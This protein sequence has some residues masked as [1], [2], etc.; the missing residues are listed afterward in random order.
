[1]GMRCAPLPCLYGGEPAARPQMGAS[2]A[3]WHQK[4]GGARAGL[5]KDLLP[6]ARAQAG[7]GDRLDDALATSRCEQRCKETEEEVRGQEKAA[8][9]EERFR[10][11]V[12][13]LLWP[14]AFLS[15]AVGVA[16]R[17]E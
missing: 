6:S 2:A 9:A 10:L 3:G 14:F 4:V 13:E 1:M 11:Q 12:L 17:G 7:W 8:A 16:W 15:R 5:L